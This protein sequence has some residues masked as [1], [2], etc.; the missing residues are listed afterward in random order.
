MG[1][2]G[3]G[4]GGGMGVGLG[5]GGRG[6]AG[7]MYQIVMQECHAPYQCCIRMWCVCV[8]VCVCVCE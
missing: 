7:H 8:C 3:V 6:G 2:E 4:G 5:G 1:E